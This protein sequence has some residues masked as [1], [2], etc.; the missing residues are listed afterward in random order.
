[1]RRRQSAGLVAGFDLD[2]RVRDP[3]ELMELVGDP[4][5]ELVSRRTSRHDDMAREGGLSR[6]HGPDVKIV[7]ARHA[8]ERFQIFAYDRRLDLAGYGLEGEVHGFSQQSPCAPY[9]H[10]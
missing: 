5:D 3:E 10:A 2:R 4:I 1:M 9:D 7:H 8:G 6:A